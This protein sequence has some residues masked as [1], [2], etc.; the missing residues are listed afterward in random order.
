MPLLK[1]VIDN[2]HFSSILWKNC[3]IHKEILE[4]NQTK[5]VRKQ[6][7]EGAHHFSL[8]VFFLKKTCVF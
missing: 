1:M 3:F 8:V 7:G 2:S 6:G 5:N 4:Q